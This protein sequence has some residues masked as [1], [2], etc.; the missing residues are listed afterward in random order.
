MF[1]SLI[2][3]LGMSTTSQYYSEYPFLDTNLQVIQ[4][5]NF[6]TLAA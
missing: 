6:V 5:L 4:D 1:L 2:I 3:L